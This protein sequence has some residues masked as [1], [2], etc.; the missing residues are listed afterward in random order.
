MALTESLFDEGPP[1]PCP[2]R[3]NMG[4]YV[5]AAAERQPD[6]DALRALD[7]T[8]VLFERWSYGALA[9]AIRA[10]AAGLQ[11]RGLERGDRVMLR[12][13]NTTDFPILFFGTIAAGGIAVPTS[14]QLTPREASALVAAT[15]PRFLCCD[16]ALGG[17]ETRTAPHLGPADWAEL[18]ASPPAD[19]AETAA[20]DPAFLIY[21]SGTGGAP[22]GVLHAHRSAWA[23]RMMWRGWYGLGPD[24]V[25]L[26]AGAFNWTYTLG[27]GLTDPWAAGAT[28]VIATGGPTASAWPEIA[29]R[30]GPTLFASV[31]GVYRQVLRA[32]GR[33]LRDAFATLRHGLTAGERMPDTLADAW[34][35]ATG[36]PVYEALGMS[37]VSTYVSSSPGVP[38]RPSRSGRP[39]TGRRVAVLTKQ[40]R[41]APLGEP[42]QLAVSRRDPG[43]MLGYWRDAEA[44]RAAHA[45]EWFLTGDRV[46]MDAD[47]YIEHLGRLDDVMTSLG[48]RVSPGEVETAMADH[49]ALADIAV[50]EL[51]VRPN[52]ALIAA[53]V[54]LRDGAVNESSLSTHAAT[55]LASYKQPKL[56][57]PVDAIPRTANGKVLRRALVEAHRR[58]RS[59]HPERQTP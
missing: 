57:I 14:S 29:Q 4:A 22:K 18:R 17:P 40:H 9:A 38:R 11:A 37:E 30:H 3:F 53:F 10:T 5:M 33:V 47:G 59:E 21:T 6:K 13:G 58:D 48:H 25:M 32:E 45:G 35:E 54:V 41:I 7:P 15:E 43:L 16:P 56:W 36:K 8:G 24:D 1:P 55:R 19:W 44:T 50:A 12:L 46:A 31:P 28:T 20:E 49:P 51:P 26:H 39:Q 52:L 23:R 34:T 42:G 27:A 2:A